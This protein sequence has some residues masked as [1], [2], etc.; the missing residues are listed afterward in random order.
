MPPSGTPAPWPGDSSTLTRESSEPITAFYPNSISG[1]ETHL[2]PRW[3]SGKFSAASPTDCGA[4]TLWGGNRG[5][6]NGT[7]SES[8]RQGSRHPGGRLLLV[9]GGGVR[10][11][12]KGGEGWNGD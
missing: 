2:P 4:A 5:G 10:S 6:C 12:P 1:R 11:A 9:P 7:G 3:R 8:I